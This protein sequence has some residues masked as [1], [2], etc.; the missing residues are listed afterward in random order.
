MKSISQLYNV[1]D[2]QTDREELTACHTETCSAL[3]SS[4]FLPKEYTCHVSVRV[5]CYLPKRTPHVAHIGSQILI[6]SLYRDVHVEVVKYFTNMKKFSR[7]MAIHSLAANA[8]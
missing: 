8:Q 6:P 2:R 3:A 5:C 7:E 4:V 1:T